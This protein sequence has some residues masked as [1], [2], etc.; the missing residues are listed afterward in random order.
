[1]LYQKFPN[2]PALKD[3]GVKNEHFIVW[4]RTA[5]LPTFRKLYGHID[6]AL[7]AGTKLEFTVYPSA[8][9]RA[10]MFVHP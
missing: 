4:M 7:P 8:C 2:Y 9:V 5:A 1:M 10:C 6:T 3:E